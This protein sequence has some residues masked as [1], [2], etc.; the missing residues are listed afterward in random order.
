MGSV[1]GG[2]LFHPYSSSPLPPVYVGTAETDPTMAAV[3]DY[4]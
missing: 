2:H 1:S 3:E 4:G